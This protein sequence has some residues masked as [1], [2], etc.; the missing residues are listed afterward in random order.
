MLR[1]ISAAF[2]VLVLLGIF[3]AANV[4]A[5]VLGP[6]LQSRLNGLA[7]DAKVGTVIIAFNTTSG[8]KP[9]NLDALR[10]V[11]ITKGITLN[12]LGM[13]ATVA[14]AGQIR[15]LSSNPS[16]RSVWFNDQ[17]HYLDFEARTLVGIER[18]KKDAGLTDRKS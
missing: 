14:T 10:A 17:L 7:A 16:V 8:L 11:G 2:T 1:R 5:A 15:A 4:S 18:L 6:S 9:S 3:T 13:V 12:H